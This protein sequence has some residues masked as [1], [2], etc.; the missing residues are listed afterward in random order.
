L[1]FAWLWS[2]EGRNLTYFPYQTCHW[3][4]FLAEFHS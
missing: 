3:I 4:L 2:V 1:A